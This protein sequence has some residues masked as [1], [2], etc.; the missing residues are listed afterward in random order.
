MAGYLIT[1]NNEEALKQVILD[2]AYS[3]ILKSPA[4]NS[5]GAPQEGTFADYLSMKTG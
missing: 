3:T 1:L 4:Y 2:G 5:W